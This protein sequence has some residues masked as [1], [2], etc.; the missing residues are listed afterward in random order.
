MS[1]NK[2]G[3]CRDSNPFFLLYGRI[4]NQLNYEVIL[5][6]GIIHYKFESVTIN[7]SFHFS[8]YVKRLGMNQRYEVTLVY[9]SFQI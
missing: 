3:T 7:K 1:K 6:Y 4:S 8:F 2:T 9:D 5:L